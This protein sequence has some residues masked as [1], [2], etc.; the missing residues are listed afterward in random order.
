MPS[1]TAD[2]LR[3]KFGPP[4]DTWPGQGLTVI[5]GDDRT[6]I[7]QGGTLIGWVEDKEFPHLHRSL[8]TFS[9]VITVFESGDPWG[10]AFPGGYMPPDP[11][12]ARLSE[13]IRWLP[14]GH[15]DRPNGALN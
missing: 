10:V 2:D 11:V 5:A 6:E 8:P 14:A 12:K 7:R 4:A 9:A 1:L 13:Q 15:P 3:L